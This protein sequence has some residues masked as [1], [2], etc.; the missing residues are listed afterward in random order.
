[1]DAP[2]LGKEPLPSRFWSKVAK[3]GG[4]WE[5]QS[6]RDARGYGRFLIGRR[7]A[8]A[9][10]VAFELVRGPIGT[11]LEVCHRCDNPP[12]VNPEHLF[13]GTH[14]DNM[15]DAAKKGRLGRRI[16]EVRP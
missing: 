14:T 5:W 2:R 12:C 15:R 1:M 6:S 13:L 11:G 10:R 9:H 16:G 7:G 3:S 4:C 8:M